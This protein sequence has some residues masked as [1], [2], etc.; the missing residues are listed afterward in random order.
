MIV[1]WR[2]AKDWFSQRGSILPGDIKCRF[3]FMSAR[4]PKSSPSV[5]W[6]PKMD[7]S[8][9]NSYWITDTISERY[10]FRFTKKKKRKT[11]WLS[12]MTAIDQ[13]NLKAVTTCLSLAPWKQV[14]KDSLILR[15]ASKRIPRK[16]DWGVYVNLTKHTFLTIFLN[17]FAK[18]Q[19]ICFQ[20]GFL[21]AENPRKK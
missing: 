3:S 8:S 9:C 11:K 7:N 21:N 4:E 10:Q 18:T 5:L 13:L 6:L 17:A 1:V 20:I 12:L 2:V 15:Q 14:S 16:C 19:K